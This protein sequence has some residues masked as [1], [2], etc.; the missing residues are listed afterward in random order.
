MEFE[1]KELVNKKRKIEKTSKKKIRL[2][3][4][5]IVEYEPNPEHYPEGASIEEMAIIDVASDDVD[6]L[7]SGDLKEDSVDYEIIEDE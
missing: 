7:F 3:R 2:I 5:M 1:A 4:T 6:L